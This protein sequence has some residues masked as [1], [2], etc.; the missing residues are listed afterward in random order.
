MLAPSFKDRPLFPGNELQRIHELLSREQI[1]VTKLLMG[2][3]LPESCLKDPDIQLSWNQFDIIYRNAYRL[4]RHPEIGLMIG[5][6]LDIT[7]WGVLGLAMSSARN[8]DHALGLAN[9]YRH[10]VRSPFNYSISRIPNGLRV[11]LI[12]SSDVD[13]NVNMAFASEIILMGTHAIIE[14]LLGSQFQFREVG[15]PYPA[16]EYAS[17][18]Q[19]LFQCPVN[20]NSQDCY[21]IIDDHFLRMDLPK[22][23]PVNYHIARRLCEEKHKQIQSCRKG[24]IVVQIQ[25]QL[26]SYEGTAVSL[27]DLATN[28]G[29]SA[30]TLRRKLSEKG[31]SFRELY[32]D[33]RKRKALDYIHNSSLDNETIAALLG[34]SDTAS[35]RKAFKR[36]MG[37]H[38][39]EY[40]AQIN[41]QHA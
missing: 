24:D 26:C 16:P 32:N 20:F 30:R 6:A 33:D 27:E 10:I 34:F 2:T 9:Y 23:N 31:T 3:G 11:K 8:I 7:R 39:K 38:P 19:E 37:I 22:S 41:R 40:Q 4:S 17:R 28:L 1:S 35:F 12:K 25:E 14:D 5:R 36:W 15:V 29:M 18:Y 21:Y 13:F